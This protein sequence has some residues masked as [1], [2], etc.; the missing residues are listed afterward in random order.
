MKSSV[1]LAALYS[2]VS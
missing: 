2:S 1:H